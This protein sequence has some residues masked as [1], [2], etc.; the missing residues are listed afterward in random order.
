MKNYTKEHYKNTMLKLFK[1]KS[2][3]FLYLLGFY[4]FLIHINNETNGC[5]GKIK[6]QI[7]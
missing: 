3:L 1:I 6:H 5:T 7:R 2:S 4:L